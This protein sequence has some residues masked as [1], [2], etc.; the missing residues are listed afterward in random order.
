MSEY[1]Y[2]EE[3]VARI[4]ALCASGVTEEVLNKL[5]EEFK[6]PRRSV[7]AK[8]RKLNFTVPLKED[9][10]VFSKDET[11]ELVAYLEANS[12]QNT[13]DE[14]A[15]HFASEWGRS[16]EGK[17]IRGKVLSLEGLNAHLK[18]AEKK[19]TPKTF[20]DAEETVITAMVDK[21]ACL[22]DIAAKL[23]R[24]VRQ[25]RGKLLS[26]RLK[27]PQRDKKASK[28]DPYDGIEALLSLTVAEIVDAFKA[29]GVEKT[30]RGIKTVLTRRKLQCKDYPSSK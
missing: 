22:E 25:I 8:L 9:K 7:A 24:E 5:V 3:H 10:P 19:V 11:E 29:K 15:S 16:V 6:F 27:A 17:Q 21:G 1:K 26:M 2:T 14:V 28:A 20:T 13:A 30:G 4:N 18:P 23:N 12:G